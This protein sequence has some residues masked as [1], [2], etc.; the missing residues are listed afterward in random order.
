[1]INQSLLASNYLRS[2]PSYLQTVD[3]QTILEPS[4]ANWSTL[5]DIKND[6]SSFRLPIFPAA[7]QSAT[8]S[9]FLNEYRQDL[10]NTG[11][12][13]L[14]IG[15]PLVYVQQNDDWLLAPLFLWS[16]RIKW[17][18]QG[19][20][21][22]WS[23]FRNAYDPLSINPVIQQSPEL[24]FVDG[25]TPEEIQ[26][27]HDFSIEYNTFDLVW[28]D[29][30]RKFSGD[31]FILFDSILPQPDLA[32]LSEITDR[33]KLLPHAV[34]GQFVSI[35][36]F[37]NTNQPTYWQEVPFDQGQEQAAPFSIPVA[38]PETSSIREKSQ[39]Y[40]F[41]E[42]QIGPGASWAGTIA[43]ILVNNA[44]A[45]LRTL[46]VSDR[47]VALEQVQQVLLRN[48]IQNLH[49]Q[50][51][52]A[53][54]D[55][56]SL[57]QL[58]RAS[59]QQPFVSPKQV[60]VEYKLQMQQAQRKDQALKESFQAWKT[61]FFG[62]YTWSQLVGKYLT[63]QQVA[64]KELLSN[65]LSTN[66][67]N[68]T[69]NEYLELLNTLAESQ[70]L[71]QKINTLSHPLREIHPD[72][73]LGFSQIDSLE[74]V[75][76]LI[77][78]H[79]SVFKRLQIE[80]LQT[81]DQYAIQLGE[82]FDRY[83]LQLHAR[84]KHLLDSAIDLET[85]FG[86]TASEVSVSSL[87]M[88][89]VFSG[90][91]RKIKGK[92][93]GIQM[94]YKNLVSLFKEKNYFSFQFIPNVESVSLEQLRANLQ[95][96][97]E[98]LRNWK[99]QWP[100]LIDQEVDRLS[101][102]HFH[103]E[104]K[105]KERVEELFLD[106]QEAITTF[107][108]D[109]LYREV[110]QDNRLTLVK[111]RQLIEQI[112]EKLETARLNLR[113][114]LDFYHWQRVW[115]S[116]PDKARKVVQALTKIDH[117][118]W[119]EAFS[120]W[121]LNQTLER[122]AKPA[123]QRSE[124]ELLAYEQEASRLLPN[125][126]RYLEKTW[127]AR[128]EQF[129]KRFKR[130]SK[131]TYQRIL[132]KQPEELVR[133]PVSYL[134]DRGLSLISH[135]FPM[136][137]AEA[138]IVDRFF[139]DEEQAFDQIIYLQW[140]KQSPL[141]DPQQLQRL[142]RRL[143][144][145]HEG[146]ETLPEQDL[147]IHLQPN[148]TQLWGD[149]DRL[150]LN[151]Q[152]LSLQ[153]QPGSSSNYTLHKTNG[154]FDPE[155]GINEAESDAIIQHL[156]RI[157][158][159]PQRTLPKVGILALS[160]QQRNWINLQLTQI[161]LGQ[162]DPAEKVRQLQR[163]GLSVF[164]ADEI[165]GSQ[166]DILLVSTTYLEDGL[167]QVSHASVYPTTQA[168]GRTLQWVE[169]LPAT[170]VVVFTSLPKIIFPEKEAI[171]FGLEAWIEWRSDLEEKGDQQ[172]PLSYRSLHYQPEFYEEMSQQMAQRLTPYLE[173]TSLEMGVSQFGLYFPLFVRSEEVW[174]P[175]VAILTDL[176]LSPTYHTSFLWEAKVRQWLEEKG[177]V[178]LTTLSTD[179]WKNPDQEAKKL[180][181][182]I[183]RIRREWAEKQEV[184]EAE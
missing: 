44:T 46:V 70:P 18:K 60:G 169:N 71:Y 152:Q 29:F 58:I 146:Q 8:I 148:Q 30:Q 96:F 174:M 85:E 14:A 141:R 82:H 159:T 57:L 80:Y 172:D 37:Q 23:L 164:C 137:L 26:R 19:Q 36:Q 89:S 175:H 55:Q 61:P 91:A 149:L 119:Q 87:R 98:Q 100:E 77:D 93:E 115:L 94:V 52:G 143:I 114:F 127:R 170:E 144:W 4:Q 110:I 147:L 11:L 179:W 108:T 155:T 162:D 151:Q 50:L 59:V 184:H 5:L 181:G 182:S 176:F 112:L 116:A 95:N 158:Y 106:L 74:R 138:S 28:K 157:G 45:G 39:R 183:L 142:S 2:F 161:S 121:Y 56:L 163:N 178:L 13:Q 120:S 126:R 117:P 7:E 136:L 68:W 156:N 16:V 153:P 150:F 124:D 103:P 125:L 73:F 154:Y 113:D 21:E 15:Y 78:K 40:A 102:K 20:E 48:S 1:M 72:I 49:Y 6:N 97:Q 53:E 62:T 47:Q 65:Q 64:G 76:H 177:I 3:L 134:L 160:K 168:L 79:Q 107:N 109:Q 51:K 35:G 86:V 67:F 104:T 75:K 135:F 133:Q 83:Y 122:H 38:G 111:K 128:Q 123:L 180:A 32:A 165:L 27:W 84:L 101:D 54:I 42:V 173:T 167:H 118:A 140:G 9:H 22:N 17:T 129:L 171:R 92:L 10:K 145:F 43:H 34:L 63:N 105:I 31:D 81:G 132:G 69:E 33:H 88:R 41:H 66:L 131:V 130:E 12:S 90:K 166:F 25:L 139:P 99:Q 24:F